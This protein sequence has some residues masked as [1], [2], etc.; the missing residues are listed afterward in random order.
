MSECLQRENLL[1]SDLDGAMM[2]IAHLMGPPDRTHSDDVVE[3]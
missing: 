3:G 2:K 1:R